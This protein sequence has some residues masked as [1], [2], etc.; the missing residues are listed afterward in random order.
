MS[1]NRSFTNEE[2]NF[3]V[4]HDM[5][6]ITMYRTAKESKDYSLDFSRWLKSN[7][8]RLYREYV[9]TKKNFPLSTMYHHN[10]DIIDAFRHIYW[11]ARLSQMYGHHVAEEFGDLHERTNYKKN[12]GLSKGNRY[13]LN[14]VKHPTTSK[15]WQYF[16]IET[17][18]SH[19]E[20]KIVLKNLSSDVDLY[21]NKDKRPNVYH[22]ICKGYAYGKGS[23]TCNIDLNEKAI[24]Y[25]G[26]YQHRPATFDLQAILLNEIDGKK[27]FYSNLSSM[28]Y[29]NN[30][31]GTILGYFKPYSSKYQLTIDVREYLL[32][33]SFLLEKRE[34]WQQ[35]V[36]N[37]LI[38]RYNVHTDKNQSK[39]VLY[40]DLESN[41]YRLMY[42]DALKKRPKKHPEI[43]YL[44][45]QYQAY[46]GE[47]EG[48]NYRCRTQH[49]C[50]D[51]I[52]GKKISVHLKSKRLQVYFKNKWSNIRTSQEI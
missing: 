40:Q 5:S 13:V 30:V 3:M 45:H 47:K 28:D 38:N 17:N 24:Y 9:M 34:K 32:N 37:T 14:K 16:R 7:R 22:Y 1:G 46:F 18:A 35:D 2:S 6:K 49:L 33:N 29:H 20:L 25:I 50:Q 12:R 4:E 10:G 8:P 19:K 15:R 27:D 36:Y 44:Y 31:I 42:F 52:N 51:F 26:L 11:S 43:E 21:V 41:N 39:A 23:E 48:V